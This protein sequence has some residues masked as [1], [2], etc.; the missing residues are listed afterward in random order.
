MKKI[1]F[2]VPLLFFSEVVLAQSSAPVIDVIEDL[3][4]D[5][6]MIV[7]KLVVATDS[8]LVPLINNPTVVV[9]GSST[10]A[11]RG[12][13]DGNGWVDLFD[14]YLDAN[15]SNYELRRLVKAG[16]TT[17]HF[18]ESGYVPSIVDR[19]SPDPSWNITRA[20]TYDPDLIIVNLPSNDVANGFD[21]QET[22]DNLNAIKA[23]AQAGGAEIVFHT[24]QPRN[25]SELNRRFELYEKSLDIK[26]LFAPDTINTYD[27]L[28]DF[29]NYTIRSEFNADDIHVNNAGHQVIY[30]RTI[31][32]V[33]RFF[34]GD[35]VTFTVSGLPQFASFEVTGNGSGE[36]LFNPGFSDSGTYSITLT[37][38]DLQGNTDVESFT[39]TVNDKEPKAG[40]QELTSFQHT[41]HNGDKLEY[42]IYYPLDYDQY[43]NDRPVLISLHGLA[44]R[45]GS[46]SKMINNSGNGSHAW[47]ANQG[48]DFPIMIVS[49]HQRGSVGGVNYVTWSLDLVKEIIEH[50]IDTYN[51]D[52]NRV[53]LTGFSNGGQSAWEYAVEYPEDIAA[54]MP[55]AGRTNLTSQGKPNLQ[56]PQFACTLTDIPIRAWHG[57]ND[58]IIPSRHSEDMVAAIN[59][60]NPSPEPPVELNLIQG[61]NHDDARPFVYANVTG[62]GNIYTWMLQAV[63]GQGIVDEIPPVFTNGTPSAV[64][65]SDTSLD[66]VASIDEEGSI[67][68]AAY[69]N[70]YMP[71]ATEVKNGTGQDMLFNGS[72][73]NIQSMTFSLTSLTPDTQYAIWVYAEDDS[74]PVNGQAN[75]TLFTIRTLP[76]IVDLDAPTFEALP[77][78]SD[79]GAGEVSVAVD[80]N[81][82]GEVYWALFPITADPVG[83]D[84][85]Q[86]S[87]A[88]Q[89]GSVGTD[90]SPLQFTI[91]SLLKDTQ[92]K[93]GL[94]AS[95]N[96]LPSN[97]QVNPFVLL[98]TTD[99][100]DEGVI[101][102]E[103][104]QLNMVKSGYS[105]GLTSWN[106]LEFDNVNGSKVFNNIRDVN[107]QIGPI[108][109]RGLN[110]ESGS[111]YNNVADNSSGYGGGTFPAEVLRHALFSTGTGKVVFQN[112]DVNKFY[113]FTFMGSRSGSGSRVTQFTLDGSNQ[114]HENVNNFTES[115]QFE[116]ISPASNG[117]LQV[118][119]RKTNSSWGYLNGVKIEVFNKLTGDIEAPG[120]VE[121]VVAE[122]IT[123]QNFVSLSWEAPS[124]PDVDS[125]AILRTVSN[126]PPSDLL[127]SMIQSGLTETSYVDSILA[128][129]ELF[130]WVIAVDGAGNYSALS[131]PASVLI[132]EPDSI[133]P[134]APQ[135]L[136]V[137]E[138]QASQVTL[139]WDENTEDDI[140]DYSIYRSIFPNVTTSDLIESEVQ[141]NEYVD[142]KSLS[143]GTIYYYKVSATDLSGNESVLSSEISA[144]TDD[145][146]SPVEPSMMFLTTGSNAINAFW[147]SSDSE[148][149]G[150]YNVYRSEETTQIIDSTV[151]VNPFSSLSKEIHLPLENNLNDISGEGRTSTN[152]NGVAFSSSPVRDGVSSAV[153]NGSSYIDM[154]TGNGFIH[155]AF[156]ERSVSLWIYPTN[157][158][159]LKDIYDEGGSTN[160][161]ALRINEGRVE[162][163][164][165][166]AQIIRLISAPITIN[167]WQHIAL[168][169]DSGQ[170]N[171]YVNGVLEDSDTSVPYNTVNSHGNGGGLGDSNS[172]TAFDLSSPGFIGNIDEF[173]AF[174][175]A[176]TASDI[177]DY[178]RYYNPIQD[179]I[180]TVSTQLLGSVVAPD[181][182]FVDN[183]ALF[184]IEYSYYVEAVDTSGNVSGFSPSES[185]V[186][187]EEVGPPDT[188]TGLMI[189]GDGNMASLEW[190]AVNTP[191]FSGYLVYRSLQPF[192]DTTQISVL[193]SNLVVTGYV[194]SPL[195]SETTYHY[196]VVAVNTDGVR[197]S[198][199]EVI[200]YSTPDFVAPDAP[201]DLVAF[202][203]AGQ[204]SLI[205][206]EGLANDI[207]GYNI[208]R[209]ADETVSITLTD[210]YSTTTATSFIDLNV[211]EGTSYSYLVTAVDDAGNESEA[212]NIVF[213]SP[214]NVS[215]PN[216]PTNLSAQYDSQQILLSWDSNTDGDFDYYTVYKSLSWF[217]EPTEADELVEN[218]TSN[219]FMDA[220]VI[221]ET[222]YFY[223]VSATDTA[224]N[225]SLISN[226]VSVTT[227]DENPPSAPVNLSVAPGDGKLVVTWDENS[228]ADLL[229]YTVF[230]SNNQLDILNQPLAS[231]VKGTGTS[232]DFAVSSENEAV[233]FYF[234][235]IANDESGNASGPSAI[236]SGQLPNTTPPSPPTGLS[237]SFSSEVMLDW[238]DNSEGDFDA[239]NLWRSN[240]T[241]ETTDDAELIADGLLL[242]N[243][244]DTDVEEMLEYFYG[245]TASD[246]SGN[247]SQL[248]NIVSVTIPDTTPPSAP[249]NLA[250]SPTVGKLVVSWD[251]VFE[252]DLANYR[253]FGAT[254]SEEVMNNQIGA[255]GASPQPTFDF[256]IVPEQ[257]GIEFFFAVVAVDESNNASIPSAQ[258]SGSAPNATPPAPPAAFVGTSI[259]SSEIELSWQE[260]TEADFS[261]YSLYKSTSEFSEIAQAELLVDGL[262]DNSFLDSDLDPETRYYYAVVASDIAGNASEASFVNA[263]TDSENQGPVLLTTIQINANKSGNSS[264]LTDW[265]DVNFNGINKSV[266]F[267]NLKDISG[268]GTG[269]SIQIFNRSNGS[270]INNVADNGSAL[271]GGILPDEVKRFA[272]FTTGKA[273]FQLQGLDPSLLY[274]LSFHSGRNGSGSRNT[275]FEVNGIT[276]TIESI[277]N[278][279]D[280]ISFV[281]IVPSGSGVVEVEFRK[282]NS[283]WGYMNALII[284]EY[285]ASSPNARL[286]STLVP[287]PEEDVPILDNGFFVYPSP[288]RDYVTIEGDYPSDQDVVMSI[289]DLRGNLVDSKK[290]T[291]KFRYQNKEAMTSGV[292][293]VKMKFADSVESTVFVMR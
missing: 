124:D 231:V 63:K 149:V 20:M 115:S 210:F 250:I 193:A 19:P 246:S 261:N 138:T 45:G 171:L 263:Q 72:A 43:P 245:V 58:E 252:D 36:F 204:I 207:S 180:T 60:C 106:D 107:G 135:N 206:N 44:E 282:A 6:G 213:D 237:A 155:S 216:I 172:S 4:L 110:G 196:G 120:S 255:V 148:D 238:D 61:M 77:V 125:Y 81:E 112:L 37:A 12:A 143:D 118:D 177:L 202:S 217:S 147:T 22:Y 86:G 82:A 131:N 5:E 35:E 292:Y 218:L 169:F 229:D 39:L 126:T 168:V 253:I 123:G 164:V 264:G 227:P 257:E 275:E 260:N 84:I 51:V 92:Y 235:V 55:I 104:Y 57:A 111:S 66:L 156:T 286:V 274:T 144:F 241:F 187:F 96:E 159:G 165:Q 3:T 28:A 114:Q 157:T 198:L 170:L 101:P 128:V 88:F 236:V 262:A 244:V 90:G 284:Q 113:S 220:N 273:V 49:P 46:P 140:K 151:S 62:E 56:N 192:A 145:V 247:V 21:R 175:S 134:A 65:I 154:D 228:E 152:Q 122:G 176:L 38:T 68:Y 13:S 224:G 174:S 197:S 195:A 54:L 182:S 74:D 205:W 11:G 266:T 59:G 279:A 226:V 34:F 285:S 31:D 30:D 98:F 76:E 293:V 17:Y 221:G 127:G 160:G 16:H 87:S 109:V 108:T 117:Q 158:S 91:S 70:G 188:P 52:R 130:Y 270:T 50:V 194:D 129:G 41:V 259:S 139:G 75:P 29:S 116:K 249:L 85:L 161:I 240:T 67:Y 7:S 232:F 243:T 133:P 53:Y 283:N 242:S 137:V 32:G 248:S 290:F 8:D 203:G 80:I 181:T 200:A 186:L 141:T 211:E 183:T 146:T 219:S 212:S 230:G 103:T 23:I 289:Y 2:I 14:D 208:Y 163:V 47:L 162:G 95:D 10:A 42:Y 287:V 288:A 277:A 281:N 222:T 215:P 100:Q 223:A 166:N 199:S 136:K 167:E 94:L 121:N 179:T 119:F 83:Q 18:R 15:F 150:L 239:Y 93:L 99:D 25:F 276:K 105:S 73:S 271:N 233:I 251:A 201:T 71:S 267:N 258:A 291:G 184:D 9:L 48:V 97:F 89:R 26:D 24:T 178:Y 64:N 280:T 173:M 40:T 185:I 79:T 209:A 33:Q 191:G 278:N 189:S 254:A 256:D 272:A 132:F 214:L 225:M 78:I 268:D 265:N 190:D 102:D 142:T 269:Y 234:Q 27:Y 69:D 153:F 1:S